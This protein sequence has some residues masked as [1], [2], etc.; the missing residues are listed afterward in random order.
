MTDLFLMY[1]SKVTCILAFIIFMNVPS[2]FY[3][4]IGEFLIK[5]F[6]AP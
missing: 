4:F 6:D 2:G 1:F 3:F 5:R